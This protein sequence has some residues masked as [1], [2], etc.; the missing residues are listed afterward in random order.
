[1][2][3]AGVAESPI[4]FHPTRQ[5]L[6]LRVARAKYLAGRPGVPADVRRAVEVNA[7]SSPRLEPRL[8]ETVVVAGYHLLGGE[9]VWLGGTL[10]SLLWVLLG[11]WCLFLIARRLASGLAAAVALG[12]YLFVPYS[13]VASRTFQPDPAMVAF[14]LAAIAALLRDRDTP[15][16]RSLVVAGAVSGT[17][18]L[19]KPTAVFVVLAAMAALAVSRGGV[20]ALPERRTI[21]L[22]ALTL[23]PATAYYGYGFVSGTATASNAETSFIAGLFGQAAYWRGW[24]HIVN[25]TVGTGF[26]LVAATA[27]LVARRREA[28]ILMAGLA[29]GYVVYGLVFNYH[30]HTHDYYSLQ[31][32]PIVALGLGLAADAAAAWISRIGVSAAMRLT[33]AAA[34]VGLGASV[35][36]NGRAIVRP[37]QSQT[38][39]EVAAQSERIGDIVSHSTRVLT[40]APAYGWPLGYYGSISGTSWPSSASGDFRQMQLLGEA[41]PTSRELFDQS[42]RTADWFVI[43]DLGELERQP[44]LRPLLDSEARLAGA[45]P[46]Y[47]VYDLRRSRP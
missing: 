42:A 44:D 8:L 38:T 11:G 1:M 27:I 35:L 17:A 3:L 39:G 28:R 23:L 46:G 26:V 41:I 10:S 19:I 13:I 32:V 21:A 40:L 2:R 7:A 14:M 24:L 18:I 45:G 12:F 9:K 36:Y 29:A 22:V 16:A 37:H 31:L 20:R 5:Y 43:T 47:L 33:A 34:L 15:D 4:T 30:I 25:G 6:G